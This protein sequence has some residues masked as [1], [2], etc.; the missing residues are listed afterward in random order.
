MQISQD[1]GGKYRA[2]FDMCDI[3]VAGRASDRKE[4]ARLMTDELLSYLYTYYIGPLSNIVEPTEAG[5]D[6]LQKKLFYARE[7]GAD[8]KY[9][10]GDDYYPRDYF[11]IHFDDLKEKLQLIASDKWKQ[12]KHGINWVFVQIGEEESSTITFGYLLSWH[13]GKLTPFWEVSID[14]LDLFE[15]AGTYEELVNLLTEKFC[16]YMEAHDAQDNEE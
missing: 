15:R 12:G 11:D 6:D 2:V 4:A 10:L 16:E 7:R 9:L 1:N 13:E 5:L 3:R 8:V 14:G